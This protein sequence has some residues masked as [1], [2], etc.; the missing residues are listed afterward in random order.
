[1]KYRK[2]VVMALVLCLAM[3]MLA[4]CSSGREFTPN[5][6]GMYVSKDGQFST[7]FEEAVDK[8][9]FTEADMLKFVVDEVVAYNK[10]KGASAVA[11]QTEAAEKEILPVSITSFTYGDKAQLILAY[12]SAKDYLAFNEKD[13]NAADELMFALAKNTTGMPDMTFVSVEDGSKI[14]AGSLVGDKKMKIVM[15]VG[16][17]NVQVQGKLVYVSENVTVTG[18]DTAITAKNGYSYLVFK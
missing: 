12:A 6:N 13:E 16:E 2:T 14:A 15:V 7:A 11:Y 4:A 1:M 8:A 9:Y 17:Q 3:S 18:E 5:G 10:S